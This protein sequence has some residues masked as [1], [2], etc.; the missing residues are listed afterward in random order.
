MGDQSTGNMENHKSERGK[1]YKIGGIA[2]LLTVA[3]AL[4]ELLLT[5]FPGGNA[6]HETVIDW[7]SQLQDNWFMGLRNLGLLNIVM[8]TFGIPMYFSL[9]TAHLKVNKAFAAFSMIVSFIGVTVFFATNRA[10]SLLELSGQYAQATSD[11]QRAIFVA[12]GQAMLSVGRSHSPGTF[13]AFFLGELA[14][15]LMSV[16]MLRG[17]IFSKTTAL[18]GI[19]GFSLLMIFE[20]C[21]SF[22]PTIS[23]VAIIFAAGGGLLNIAWLVLLGR[24]LLQLVSKRE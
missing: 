3:V 12:A 19:A 17:G 1:I 21:A 13:I 16:V 8:F 11:A 2:A 20:V 24:R 23:G 9:Y 5:F 4:V 18:I 14:G 22:I 15:I 10:F 7:F 6:S